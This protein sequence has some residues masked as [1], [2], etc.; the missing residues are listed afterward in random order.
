VKRDPSQFKKLSDSTERLP[1]QPHVSRFTHHVLSDRRT[2]VKSDLDRLMLE[3]NYDALLV[4]GS[5]HHNPP[6]YYLANGASIGESSILLKKRGQ[7]PVLFVSGMERDE[8]ARSGLQVVDAARY[9][10]RE[11]VKEENGDLLRA[12]ARM[13]GKIF[14]EL[15]VQ[16]TVAAFGYEDQGAAYALLT[17]VE[18]INPNIR[19]AGEYQKT[20]LGL[21]R[22]TKD[23]E[24]VKRI[25]AVARKTVA[26]VGGVQEFLVSHRAKNGYLVKKDGSR[27]NVGDVKLHIN[28][29]LMAHDIVDAEGA[30]IFAI[31]RDA[32]VPHSRGNPR[33]PIALGQTIVFDIFPAEPGGGYFYD[34]TRTWCLGYAPDHV[35]AAYEEVTTIFKRVMK[36]LKPGAPCSDYQKMTADFFEAHGHP[37]IQS[38]PQTTDGYVHSLGHGIGLQ[39]HERPSLNDLAGNTATLDPGTVVTV[40]PGL[41][42]PDHP[43]GG[44]GIRV[45]DSVWLNPKTLKFEVLGKYPYDLVLPVK[46]V[47]KRKT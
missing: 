41:Y 22:E 42:Y 6:M 36:A 47:S 33:D 35:Q 12:R 24:E 30:T 46:Q 34:F 20:I 21:A 45:E 2:L 37:T 10:Y 13:F 9:N 23:A 3:R 14:A 32:G 7:A 15:G 27:L 43:K 40:E 4:T 39:V 16:G 31:G 19:V 1:F 44:F 17:A 29:L 18:E 11:L 38:N 8:A 28:H 5:S 26:V 25:R